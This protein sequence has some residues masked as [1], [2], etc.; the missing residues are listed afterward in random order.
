[1]LKVYLARHG[2]DQDNLAGVL[3]GHRDETLTLE[4]RRQADGLGL[5]V[6]AATAGIAAVYSSPLRRASE[7]ATIIAQHAGLPAPIAEKLLI[8]RDF[9]VM[10]GKRIADITS[11]CAPD[12]IHAGPVTYFL[13]PPGA[14]TFPDLMRRA[15]RLLD[16]LRALHSS[17]SVLLV[18]HGDTGK[19]L[20][21][22][23][24]GLDW[25]AVLTQFHF[26]NCDLLV[27][28]PP[29]TGGSARPGG[30]P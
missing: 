17:G 5:K 25:K 9:G 1:M 10:T 20:Y 21:A 19:M 15:Q 14:E 7:T 23:Y 24:Y 13:S 30:I 29:A 18:T 11:L 3:N 27:L 8:E 4:G 12:I 16:K 22:A 28:S 26:G 2:Q 6:K